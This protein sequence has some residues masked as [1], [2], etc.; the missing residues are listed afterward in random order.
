MN[1]FV[2]LTSFLAAALCGLVSRTGH[3]TRVQEIPDSIGFRGW[4]KPV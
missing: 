4:W 2:N 1:D 3:A